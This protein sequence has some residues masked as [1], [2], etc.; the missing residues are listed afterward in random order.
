MGVTFEWDRR[1]ALSNQRKHGVGFEEA[2]TVFD[3]PLAVIFD[4]EGTKGL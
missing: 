1:K 2:I 3:D 4:G